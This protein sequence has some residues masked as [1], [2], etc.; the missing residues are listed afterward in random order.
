MSKC[1]CEKECT[2]TPKFSDYQFESTSLI[3]L[4]AMGR[5]INISDPGK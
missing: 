4:D 3:Q 2:C 5:I 1:D